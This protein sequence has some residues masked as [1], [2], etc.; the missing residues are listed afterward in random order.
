MCI[1]YINTGTRIHQ[2]DWDSVGIITLTHTVLYNYE[3]IIFPKIVIFKLNH[4]NS[5]YLWTK[6]CTHV[7]DKQQTNNHTFKLIETVQ[8]MFLKA[9]D[10]CGFNMML[11]SLPCPMLPNSAK[12]KVKAL[13]TA[14]FELDHPWCSNMDTHTRVQALDINT[15]HTCLAYLVN[16]LTAQ[17]ICTRIWCSQSLYKSSRSHCEFELLL[18]SIL[19]PSQ[20]N[21]RVMIAVWNIFYRV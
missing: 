2:H 19:K 1:D 21:F 13:H 10:E 6:K 5:I 15:T 7:Q 12:R 8:T 4:K 18:L 3:N 11:K 9:N 20:P 17:H 16:H 14:L